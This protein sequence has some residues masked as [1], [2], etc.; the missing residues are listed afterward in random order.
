MIDT[1][2]N[3]ITHDELTVMQSNQFYETMLKRP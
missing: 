1:N 3:Q 2:K